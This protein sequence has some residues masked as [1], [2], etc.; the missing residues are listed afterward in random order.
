MFY[1]TF[2]HWNANVFFFIKIG[3]IKEKWLVIYKIIATWNFPEAGFL[4]KDTDNTCRIFQVYLRPCS[5]S[6]GG[7]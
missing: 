5:E 7:W 4:D 6:E 3:K 2:V 1:W